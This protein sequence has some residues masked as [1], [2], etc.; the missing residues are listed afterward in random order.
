MFI[1]SLFRVLYMMNLLSMT[2]RR[3]PK[4]KSTVKTKNREL[5]NA[6]Q[7]LCENGRL[8]KRKTME[9]NAVNVTV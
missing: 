4:A 1:F 8:T 5:P 2:I 7:L 9:N 3:E 6:I